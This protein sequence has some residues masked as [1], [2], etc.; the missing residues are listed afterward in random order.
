[1]RPGCFRGGHD[2]STQLHAARARAE[3]V[4][5]GVSGQAELLNNR[6]NEQNEKLEKFRILG[7]KV[8]DLNATIS[9]FRRPH[10]D[11]LTEE[12]RVKLT[13]NIP[14]FEAQLAVLIEELQDLRQSARDSRMK[15]LEKSAESLTQTL[16]AV[17]TKLRDLGA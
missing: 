17:R 8:G 1:M 15:T 16:Q 12:D 13:S 6:T 9:Q 11:R 10:G 4:A 5:Q 14:A 7:E 2:S 3:A